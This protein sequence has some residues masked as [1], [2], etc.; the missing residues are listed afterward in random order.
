VSYYARTA[1]ELETKAAKFW[2]K[3][4]VEKEATAGIIPLLIRTQEKFISLLDI[5]D[6]SPDAWKISLQASGEL[7]PICFLNI[8]WFYLM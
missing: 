1:S 5:S 3:D 6:S 2:P 8:Y 7:Y 4:L